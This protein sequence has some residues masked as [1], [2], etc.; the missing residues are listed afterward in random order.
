MAE[1][2]LKWHP[3]KSQQTGEEKLDT[4]GKEDDIRAFGVIAR[5]LLM[6]ETVIPRDL[7]GKD[8]KW[9]IEDKG[10]TSKTKAIFHSKEEGEDGEY[11]LLNDLVKECF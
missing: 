4:Q 7:E 1:G 2:K 5:E 6:H 10:I 3:L 9:W 11:L 8:L